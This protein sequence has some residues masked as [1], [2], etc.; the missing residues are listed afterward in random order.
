M[1]RKKQPDK[2]SEPND[3]NS[4]RQSLSVSDKRAMLKELGEKILAA[5][6]IDAILIDLKEDIINYFEAERITIYVVDGTTKELV[7]RFMS[8]SE[9][10][11]IRIPI[12]RKSIAGYAALNQKI[13]N[14]AD[15]N[16]KTELQQIGEGLEFDK[17]W[18]DR[19]GFTTRQVLAVPI[20]IRNY[21]MGVME[22]MNRKNGGVFT[23]EDE[24]MALELARMIGVNLFNRK[25]SVSASGA[26]FGY[27][28]RQMVL[29]HNDLSKAVSESVK[30]GR[31]PENVLMEHYG[32]SKV[33]IG[34]SLADYYHVPFVEFDPFAP[35]PHSLLK[36]LK[37]RF[38]KKSLWVPI[39]Q[40]KNA[41]FV[42]ID[43]PYDLWRVDEIRAVFPN[44]T[45]YLNVALKSDILAFI[46]HFTAV[47]EEDENAKPLSPAEQF[48]VE[49]EGVDTEESFLP[50]EE[51]AAPGKAEPTGAVDLHSAVANLFHSLVT[52]ALASNASD[53]HV[54]P[55]PGNRN[56]VVRF[57]I[58]GRLTVYATYPEHVTI[59]L[60]SR[61]KRMAGLDVSAHKTPQNGKIHWKS[62]DDRRI[63]LLTTAI[64][65]LGD[66]EALSVKIAVQR[67]AA[68][69]QDCGF[70]P[71]I[72]EKAV[73]H[74]EKPYGLILTAGAAASG[75]NNTL[76]SI[77]AHINTID[78]KIWTIEDPI[79]IEHKTVSQVR[80]RRNQ[81]FG[82]PEA[83]KFVLQADPD[84]VMIGN[85]KDEKTAAMAVEAAL[86][87]K[88]VL[89]S[90]FADDTP[91]CITKFLEMR[92]NSW[93]L[94]NA[95][96]C[97]L[98]Q[99]LARM[100]CPRC[101]RPKHPDREEYDDLVREYGVEDFQKGPDIPYSKDLTL[102][103]PEGCDACRH[104]GYQGRTAIFEF[105]PVDDEMKRMIK[106]KL[107]PEDLR[108]QAMR[109]GM[110]TLKQEG[111][112]KV[113][114]G[115]TDMAEIRRLYIVN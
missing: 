56:S 9:I 5:K 50:E 26:E 109:S 111:I 82:Y 94:S 21:L 74:I 103:T 87:G 113:F 72:Y 6:N 45:L 38:L 55:N 32:V 29:S 36:G 33:L 112:L 18:D 2:P 14:I 69:L 22:V 63:A 61:I 105:M 57:R 12:S 4:V 17:R 107:G 90:V 106:M 75:K 11:E 67:R 80:L 70:S 71:G 54:E 19:T 7:S 25:K 40:E 31:P 44:M 48:A 30:T 65:V 16:D 115:I 43:D 15:V 88:R 28:V 10:A 49:E 86:S 81:G 104:T 42:A 59:E 91:D 8:K 102:Y 1:A 85:I 110:T 98:A 62:P 78:T 83:L 76:H 100:L 52:E 35:V 53:I 64:P 3:M 46:D 84:A 27:L 99:R 58:D 92:I 37:T 95:L 20:I 13:L 34:E 77:V 68:K 79:E 39:R 23:P 114:N 60:I 97:I 73:K 93:N 24:Q 96:S 101:K 51:N 66:T 108:W 89:G 47:M 41:A